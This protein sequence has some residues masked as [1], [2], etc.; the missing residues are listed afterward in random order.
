MAVL[1]AVFSVIIAGVI[2]KRAQSAGRDKIALSINSGYSLLV[3]AP[4]SFFIRF[5]SSK[6]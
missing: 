5:P 2:V 3:K 1:W 6:K 4:W